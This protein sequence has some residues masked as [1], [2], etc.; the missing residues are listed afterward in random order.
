MSQAGEVNAV[1]ANPQIPTMFVTNDGIAIPLANTLDI[2]GSGSIQTSGAANVVTIFLTGLTNHAV[3]VGAGTSTITKVGPT[4]NT[5]A[6]LQNNAGADPSYSTATYPSTTTINQL[7]YS[8]ANNVVSGLANGTTGQVLTATTGGAPSWQSGG[9]GAV[10][11]VSGTT[12]RITATPTTGAV[13]VDISAAYVGQ[14]SITTLG[15]ITTGIWNGTAVDATHGGTNQTTWTT[16]DLLYASGANTLSKLGIGTASQVLTVSGGLP[17]WQPGGS[18]SGDVVGPA[19]ATDNA[20]AR[21]NGTTGKL[22]QNSLFVVADDGN[23]SVSNSIGSGGL[24]H[25]INNTSSANDSQA[26]LQ[27]IVN[28]LGTGSFASTIYDNGTAS[29]S[30]GILNTSYLVGLGLDL[31]QP[32]LFINGD[33]SAAF[34]SNN[35]SVQGNTNAGVVFG[36]YNA[37]T[38]VGGASVNITGSGSGPVYIGFNISLPSPN[39]FTVG[40]DP[41]T[42]NFQ[43][44]SAFGTQTFMTTSSTG[45]VSYPLNSYIYAVVPTTQSLTNLGNDTIIYGTIVDVQNEYDNGTGIFTPQVDG[46][47]SVSATITLDLSSAIIS[48]GNSIEFS[49]VSGAAFFKTTWELEG[50]VSSGVCCVSV[51]ATVP[52]GP[53]VPIYIDAN[54][55]F[56]GTIQTNGS[57][58]SN[59]LTIAKVA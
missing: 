44:T 17:S 28:G 15:T 51:S 59:F 31:T 52:G 1:Q 4:A 50:H 40:A 33:T 16:G 37:D 19:S 9:G 2:F 36:V 29:F 46:F 18:G 13:V 30:S 32:V 48:P 10:S 12:N 45:I 24:N 54:A 41:N 57:Q 27:L 11:S 55:Q 8:S 42:G 6:V 47:Y 14:S 53:T 5:G 39:G 38:G 26:S 7:L 43:M 22:I 25:T 49:I 20:V 21:Y 58:D 23:S 56:A 34:V 3:L 35:V